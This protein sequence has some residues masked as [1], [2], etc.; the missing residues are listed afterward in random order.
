MTMAEA[1]AIAGASRPLVLVVEDEAAIAT[2]LR[3]NLEKQ[4][5]RVEEASDGQEALLRLSEMRPDIVLLD[6][7]GF[8]A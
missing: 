7:P 6:Y 4:G 5:F 1:R 8:P 2:M 3:Y